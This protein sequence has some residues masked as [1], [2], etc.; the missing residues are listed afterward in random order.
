MARVLMIELLDA[1]A[2]IGFH[3]CDAA[4]LEIVA[5][6]ALVGE[7]RLALDERGHAAL[8]HQLVDE[9]VVLLRVRRKMHDDAVLF[10]LIR[11]LAEI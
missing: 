10:R 4:R 5:H 1:F 8:A 3:H 9:L 2:E 11:E 6:V 7:H